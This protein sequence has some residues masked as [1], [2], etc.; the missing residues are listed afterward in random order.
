MLNS[1]VVERGLVAMQFGMRGLSM[2]LLKEWNRGTSEK[3]ATF[4]VFEKEFG[5]QKLS[6]DFHASSQGVSPADA[7][8]RALERSLQGS[9]LASALEALKL[10]GATPDPR[11]VGAALA[12][13]REALRAPEHVVLPCELEPQG[14]ATE[15]R[16]RVRAWRDAEG[17][18]GSDPK[19]VASDFHYSPF[20][21]LTEKAL[22]MDP[23]CVPRCRQKSVRYSV[24]VES[25]DKGK[26]IIKRIFLPRPE[27]D[28]KLRPP[29]TQY[30]PVFTWHVETKSGFVELGPF[31]PHHDRDS[32]K[33]D[34]K[35]SIFDMSVMQDALVGIAATPRMQPTKFKTDIFGYDGMVTVDVTKT[36]MTVPVLGHA[37][38]LGPFPV[39][40]AH[41]GEWWGR[42]MFREDEEGLSFRA[43][44]DPWERL[45]AKACAILS[46]AIRGQFF[47]FEHHGE[48]FE[49]DLLGYKVKNLRT[50]EEVSTL[51][52][53]AGTAFMQ[54]TDLGAKEYSNVP[55]SLQKFVDEADTYSTH[56]VQF[57]AFSGT[58]EASLKELI[59]KRISGNGPERYELRPPYPVFHA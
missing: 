46:S 16:A 55:P 30:I 22:E 2:E 40:P 38:S 18:Y 56:L 50:L 28:L 11:A 7:S 43:G 36:E 1:Q 4:S 59:C 53:R 23:A 37:H 34:P 12:Q 31:K 33:Q 3:S 42:R 48:H 49:A 5:V 58:M 39:M 45:P 57:V 10:L 27:I 47:R 19:Q 14:V 41:G 25:E 15:A 13:V 8:K 26:P 21:I 6:K 24:P 32:S 17:Q 20:A 29:C 51:R 52:E 35:K 9:T 54:W 44:R